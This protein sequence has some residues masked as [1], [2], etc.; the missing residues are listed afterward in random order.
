MA[1]ERITSGGGEGA[2]GP[3][4]QTD[5]E[6]ELTDRDP[7]S[8]DGGGSG[9]DIP[10]SVYGDI[11]GSGGGG[12]RGGSSGG[13]DRST[14]EG[15][16]SGGGETTTSPIGGG[17]SPTPEEELTDRDP[18]SGDGDGSESGSSSAGDSGSQ[19]QSDQDVQDRVTDVVTGDLSGETASDEA[20]QIAQE[21]VGATL[22]TGLEGRAGGPEITQQARDLEEQAIAQS[23]Y[24]DDPSDVAIVEEEGRLV[25]QL[26]RSGQTQIFAGL[27]D[28]NMDQSTGRETRRQ[29]V[30]DDIFRRSKPR[31]G[32]RNNPWRRR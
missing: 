9:L 4:G 15:I 6:E 11:G 23:P 28:R 27:I 7:G 20:E 26:S 10:D 2:S 31:E 16:T 30:L 19:Q 14:D 29:R 17:G 24:I 1:D 25:A 21:Q 32:R 5:A 18:G 13:D 3:G 22:E 8:G 12:S